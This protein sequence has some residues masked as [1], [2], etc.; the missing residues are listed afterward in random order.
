M[1]KE[2]LVMTTQ[3]NPNQYAKS[4]EEKI[5]SPDDRAKAISILEKSRETINLLR[6]SNQFNA[7]I[8]H[9]PITL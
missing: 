3:I 2:E 5:A 9:E 6:T 4:I 7:S 8:L 1:I